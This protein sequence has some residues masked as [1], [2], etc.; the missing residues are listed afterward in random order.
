M[1]F[2]EHVRSDE[3]VPPDEVRQEKRLAAGPD[4]FL[5]AYMQATNDVL[6]DDFDQQQLPR[7]FAA[8]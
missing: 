7:A 8:F 2:V 4:V 6:V 1:P 3:E 5:D